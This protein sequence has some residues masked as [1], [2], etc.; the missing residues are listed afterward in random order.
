[1]RNRVIQD[2]FDIQ[3][4]E[5]H[6]IENNELKFWGYVSN[7][8]LDHKRPEEFINVV[9]GQV[10]RRKPEETDWSAD[11]VLLYNNIQDLNRLKNQKFTIQIKM[12]DPLTNPEVMGTQVTGPMV[13]QI[14]YIEGC[15]IADMNITVS[16]SSTF[17]MSGR[18]DGWRLTDLN[19]NPL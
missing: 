19:G 16:D 10:R 11:N 2:A 18:A 3:E 6:T 8:T 1:M 14:L 17:K 9:G 12:I 5:I 7:V 4:G 15:R 13:G